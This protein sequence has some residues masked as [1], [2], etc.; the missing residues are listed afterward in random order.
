[1]LLL[2]LWISPNIGYWAGVGPTAVRVRGGHGG[3]VGGGAGAAGQRPGVGQRHQLGRVGGTG[4]DYRG[5]TAY[6]EIFFFIIFKII[7]F[8]NPEEIINH[9]DPRHYSIRTCI[10]NISGSEMLSMSEAGSVLGNRTLY[11][12]KMFNGIPYFLCASLQRNHSQ[13]IAG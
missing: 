4:R 11:R 7:K 13:Y 10:N 8:L 3:Q 6:P 9:Q 2:V 1:M 5:S 12:K